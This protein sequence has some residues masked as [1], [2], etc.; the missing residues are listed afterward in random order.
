MIF[1]L[2]LMLVKVND[3]IE[4]SR[5]LRLNYSFFFSNRLTKGNVIIFQ[6]GIRGQAHEVS[7]VTKKGVEARNYGGVSIW[8]K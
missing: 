7:I 6:L 8:S 5:F 2:F 4:A 1:A 3:G